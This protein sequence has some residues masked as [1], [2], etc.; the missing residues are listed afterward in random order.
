MAWNLV[1]YDTIQLV[2]PWVV[3]LEITVMLRTWASLNASPTLWPQS[4]DFQR[5]QGTE[6]LWRFFFIVGR[7][8]ILLMKSCHLDHFSYDLMQQC[9]K[10]SYETI[11]TSVLPQKDQNMKKISQKSRKFLKVLV[12]PRKNCTFFGLCSYET[13]Y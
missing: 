8:D 1:C 10:N 2:T 7:F 11:C 5:N 4:P 13:K 12:V 9:Q 6:F 3:G